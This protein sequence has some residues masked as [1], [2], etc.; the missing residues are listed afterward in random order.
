MTR[1]IVKRLIAALI[2]MFFLI[3]ITFFLMHAIPG[4]PF[5]AGEQKDL[6]PEIL[7]AIRTTGQLSAETE[8]ALKGALAS[9]TDDFLKSKGQTE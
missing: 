5:S 3:T 9:Y 6:N 2:S 8:E 1:Y 4:G 7:E